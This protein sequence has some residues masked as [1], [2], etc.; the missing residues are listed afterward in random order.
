MAQ[1][2]ERPTLAQVMISRFVGSNPALG[3]VLTAQNLET[4]SHPVSP[5]FSAPLLLTHKGNILSL[6]NKHLRGTWVAQS[7]KRPTLAQVM[8]SLFVGSSPTLGSVLTAGSLEPA[9]DSVSPSLS[10]P[11]PLMLCLSV[12]LSLKNK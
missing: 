6:K 12:S 1:S 8:I 3:C 7:V 4:A 11:P 2:V 10:A 9:S 5:S